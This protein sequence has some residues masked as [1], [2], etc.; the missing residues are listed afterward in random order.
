M[1]GFISSESWIHKT[2][3]Q[4]KLGIFLSLVFVGL[5]IL[6]LIILRV[7]SI[8]IFG[9]VSDLKLLLSLVI[10]FFMSFL[11]L[12]LG[13]RCSNCKK[14]PAWKLLTKESAGVWLVQLMFMEDC[15]SCKDKVDHSNNS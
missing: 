7:K 13:I 14:S 10:L 4:W 5:F 6:S 12:C 9:E 1:M 2:K 11:W 8:W 3:Q 15:P